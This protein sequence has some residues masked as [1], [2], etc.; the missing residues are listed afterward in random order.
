MAFVLAFARGLP[1]FSA[2]QARAEWDRSPGRAGIVDLA[3]TTVLLV[4]VGQVGVEVARLCRT[5]GMR[6]VGVDARPAEVPPVVDQLRGP[7]GLDG[8]LPEADFVVLTVPHTPDTDG[9]INADRLRLMRPSAVLVN[10]GRGATV[11]LDDLVAA[12]EAGRLAGAALDV[13][14]V[15]PLPE[16]HP[17]WSRTDVLITP[18]VAGFGQDTDPERLDVLLDNA[19]RFVEGRPLRYVVDKERWF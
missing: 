7:D 3:A 16:T 1:W 14:E 8:V 10:V 6:V 5:F 9:M 17:L 12:L 2:R 18:H 19:R 4:G 15:E 13:F 11:C